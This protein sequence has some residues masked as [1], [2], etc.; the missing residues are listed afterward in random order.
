MFLIIQLFLQGILLHVPETYIRLPSKYFLKL[1]SEKG[2]NSFK[3]NLNP[4]FSHSSLASKYPQAAV[5]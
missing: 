3:T 2:L 1:T 4:T 5:M